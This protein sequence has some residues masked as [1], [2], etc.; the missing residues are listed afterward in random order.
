[1]SIELASRSFTCYETYSL[2]ILYTWLP[3]QS[4]QQSIVSIDIDWPADVGYLFI[5]LSIDQYIYVILTSS[6]RLFVQWNSIISIDIDWRA[7]PRSCRDSCGWTNC[8]THVSGDEVWRSIK[9]RAKIDNIDWT[10]CRSIQFGLLQ[11]LSI[12]IM[13][14]W[15]S[16]LNFFH[17]LYQLHIFTLHI[18][19]FFV[20]FFRLTQHSIILILIGQSTFFTYL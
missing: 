1:M 15:F 16:H 17:F 19:I 18:V 10:G 2:A 12:G 8:P 4:G 7:D 9:F 13:C 14:R 11:C 6:G 20:F 3:P 5:S